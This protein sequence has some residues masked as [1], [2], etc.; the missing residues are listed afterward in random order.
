MSYNTETVFILFK[1]ARWLLHSSEFNYS[2][3]ATVA[4]K[5]STGDYYCI[6]VLISYFTN[7]TITT[8]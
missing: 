4:F 3:G 2:L 1:F 6:P 8:L 5:N 7:I